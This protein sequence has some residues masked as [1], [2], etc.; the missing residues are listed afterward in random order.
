M[1]KPPM[2]LAEATRLDTLRSLNILDTCPE[3]RFDRLTRLAKRLFGVPIALVSLVDADRQWFKSCIGLS[4]TETPRE[5]SFCGHAIL[6]DEIFLV[7]DAT[8]DERFHDNPLVLDEPRIR[9]YAGCPLT[10]PNGSKLGTLCL[11]DVEPRTLGPDDLHLLRDLARMAE[12]ELAAVQ[13]A[14][15]DELTLLS[16]RRGFLALSQHALNLCR[17]VGTPASLLFLDMDR[18]KQINDRFG[19]AEGDR[20]LCSFG[21][22]LKTVF[23]DSDVIGRMGGDEFAVLLTN[24]STHAAAE[25]LDRLKNA[26]DAL[27]RESQRGYEV[28]FSAGQLAFDPLRHSSIDLLLKEADALMYAQKR[29]RN[30]RLAA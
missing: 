13:L 24:T 18:F 11:I 27:N 7:P 6:E 2:P 22:V 14:T 25:A 28:L 23:R 15:M 10:V 3:E 20:A 16:N 1:I 4:A 12:Q 21:N 8:L 29:A 9:F 5:I 17:R 19:H 26:V 30:E